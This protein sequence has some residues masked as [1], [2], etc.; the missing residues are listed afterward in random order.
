MKLVLSL[1]LNLVQTQITNDVATTEEQ[2]SSLEFVEGLLHVFLQARVCRDEVAGGA[3]LAL[4]A[5][6]SSP[7]HKVL[8]WFGCEVDKLEVQLV[9][10]NVTNKRCVRLKIDLPNE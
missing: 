7:S 4:I 9:A 10:L 2:F 3:P 8:E 5:F 6:F 1:T